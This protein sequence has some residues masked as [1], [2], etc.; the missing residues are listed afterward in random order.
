MYGRDGQFR[1]EPTHSLYPLL[2]LPHRWD[3]HLPKQL[4]VRGKKERTEE[5]FDIEY[6]L[7]LT[8]PHPNGLDQ[9]GHEIL[10]DI[11]GWLIELYW[12]CQSF[13]MLI[14]QR[15]EGLRLSLVLTRLIVQS[16]FN[17]C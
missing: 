12:A 17:L 14:E 10:S 5:S 6:F 8:P 1:P 13:L 9:L 4:S 16:E 2:F 7:S 11:K 15:D 3:H